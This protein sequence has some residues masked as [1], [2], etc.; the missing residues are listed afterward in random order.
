MQTKTITPVTGR[1]KWKKT[2]YLLVIS[3]LLL[4]L[5][6]AAMFSLG[7]ASVRFDNAYDKG[8]DLSPFFFE[9]LRKAKAT[10]QC[11][12]FGWRLRETA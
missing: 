2:A 11:R 6:L 1:N 8:A 3:V 7:T 9:P 10:A 5:G 12:S 4:A